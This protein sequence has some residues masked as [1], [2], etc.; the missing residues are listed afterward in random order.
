MTRAICDVCSR[1]PC[2]GSRL[3][4]LLPHPS[5]RRHGAKIDL[6]TVITAVC[7]FYQLK[8]SELVSHRKARRF[9]DPR[10]VTAYLARTYTSASYPNIGTALGGR[11]HTTVMS[12]YR[13]VA[14]KIRQ[15]GTMR[16]EVLAIELMLLGHAGP[17]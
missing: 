1:D 2:D 10:A 3:G 11:H 15:S 17:S 12:G 13:L 4:C 14:T 16:S 8:K 5:V 9:S 6:D 7:R